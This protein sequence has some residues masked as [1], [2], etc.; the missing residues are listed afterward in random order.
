MGAGT[1]WAASFSDGMKSRSSSATAAWA[2][3]GWPGTAF[4]RGRPSSN[5]CTSG[6]PAGRGSASNFA[7]GTPSY[8]CLELLRGDPADHRGDIYSLGVVL[9]EL[10]TGRLPF[11][12]PD[13]QALLEAHVHRRPPTFREAGMGILP[14]AVERVVQQCL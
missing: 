7:A 2:R 12:D 11:A 5:F 6:W 4:S 1:C 10:L 13:T 14:P 9:F 3:C 8:V